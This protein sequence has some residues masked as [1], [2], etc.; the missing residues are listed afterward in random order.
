MVDVN[1]CKQKVAK[2]PK[3]SLLLPGRYESSFLNFPESIK[4]PCC[5]ILNQNRELKQ[6]QQ[7]LKERML[8]LQETTPVF[9][10]PNS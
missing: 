4:G 3:M 8:L 7:F 9:T 6:L 1:F 10:E 5:F 2:M